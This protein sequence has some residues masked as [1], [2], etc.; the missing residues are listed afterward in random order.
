MGKFNA[1]TKL[2]KAC[3]VSKL[4]KL[5]QKGKVGKIANAI[6]CGK[7]KQRLFLFK[8]FKK[9]DPHLDK[10]EILENINKFE[11]GCLFFG[12]ITGI[13]LALANDIETP[14]G[15]KYADKALFALGL[16]SLGFVL[17][18]PVGA[19]I[20]NTIGL[21]SN[22]KVFQ[23]LQEYEQTKKETANIENKNNINLK[24]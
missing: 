5:T 20:G 13:T 7:L 11:H 16:G 23:R 6:K 14:K 18:G 17:G 10:F 19:I 4:T 12:G 22:I 9:A 2:V 1:I 15:A 3:N 8:D 21:A 24:C